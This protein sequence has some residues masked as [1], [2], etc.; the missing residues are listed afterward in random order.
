M[1]PPTIGALKWADC[2]SLSTATGSPGL[3]LPPD[4]SRGDSHSPLI[5]GTINESTPEPIMQV[6]I[7]PVVLNL[8]PIQLVML[9]DAIS[10]RYH[11]LESVVNNQELYPD[12]SAENS[13]RVTALRDLHILMDR[14]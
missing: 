4:P 8:T 2:R 5:H 3:R 6:Q 7:T 14:Y 12:Q 10:Y 11:Q 9:Q 13:R 1:M